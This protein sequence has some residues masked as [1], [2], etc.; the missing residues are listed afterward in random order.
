M[1]DEIDRGELDPPRPGALDWVLFW[2]VLPFVVLGPISVAVLIV[3]YGA[4]QP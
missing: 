1:R 3:V 4:V 2:M